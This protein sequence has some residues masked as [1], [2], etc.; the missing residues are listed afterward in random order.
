[1][2]PVHD[3]NLHI[4][5]C[6]IVVGEPCNKSN[7]HSACFECNLA[8]NREAGDLVACA[9]LR[10]FPTCTKYL[11]FKVVFSDDFSVRV[12]S[13]FSFGEGTTITCSNPSTKEELASRSFRRDIAETPSDNNLCSRLKARLRKSI[14]H[15]ILPLM[16][17]VSAGGGMFALVHRD[18]LLT[19]R[20][21]A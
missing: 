13:K 11:I 21:T 3:S 2:G 18:Y 8:C 16:A 20:A 5:S 14:W 19:C 6:Q 12:G 17:Y 9:P 10:L 15:Q 7:L 4:L 1:M